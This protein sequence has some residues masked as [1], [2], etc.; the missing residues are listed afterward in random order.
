V[1]FL[2]KEKLLNLFLLTEAAV[3][4]IF[5]DFPFC[6]KGVWLCDQRLGLIRE[7]LLRISIWCR[8]KICSG[9]EF[10]FVNVLIR[11]FAACCPI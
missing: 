1:S 11:I 2:L 9:L 7:V 5:I 6:C 3:D 10:L 4:T 8:T